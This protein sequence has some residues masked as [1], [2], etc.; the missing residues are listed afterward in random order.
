[1]PFQPSGGPPARPLNGGAFR[2]TAYVGFELQKC[3]FGGVGP[4]TAPNQ[5]PCPRG[6]RLYNPPVPRESE[7]PNLTSAAPADEA[8]AL[9]PIDVEQTDA[10]AEEADVRHFA[11]RVA[12]NLTRRIDQY[13][14]DRVGYL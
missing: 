14:V 5:R 12:K 13:L 7:Q 6:S 11:W 2:G 1:M 9:Q 3:L 10:A 8:D 4:V